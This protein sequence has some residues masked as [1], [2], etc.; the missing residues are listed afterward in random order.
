[1]NKLF[2]GEN[3]DK[4]IPTEETRTELIGEKSHTYPVYKIPLEFFKI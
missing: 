2:E 1:M 3:R 4:L